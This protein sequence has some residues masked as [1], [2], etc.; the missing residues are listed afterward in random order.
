MTRRVLVLGGGPDAERDISLASAAAIAAALRT[1]PEL[2]VLE[3]TVDRPTPDEIASW[4]QGVVFPALHGAFGEGGP[5][6]DRLETA[7]R[8]YVGCGP[9][10]ARLAMDKLATKIEAALAGVPTA[11]AALI[12]P[13][14][15]RPPLPTPLVAKPVREGS[16][17]GLHVCEHDG[18]WADALERVRRARRA[19]M[20]ERL[21]RGRELTVGLIAGPTGA[22]TALPIV[23]IAPA[24]GVYDYE[25]KYGRTDTVY[26]VEPDLPRDA[27]A[28][29]TEGALRLADRLGVR[30]LARVDFLLGESGP[31]LLEI[32]TMPGFTRSSLVP[33]AAARLGLDLPALCLRLVGVAA[34]RAELAGWDTPDHRAPLPGRSPGANTHT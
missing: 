1:V 5:M 23:E 25:A 13:D 9:V 18:A 28:A 17:V 16:S 8:A 21:I 4:P 31:L 7:G 29:M 11:S 24:S 10:A 15:D 32:N 22:M 6:Q 2:E 33:K 26:R 3:L 30:D 12:D 34:R 20:A 27:A 19:Y 14:D